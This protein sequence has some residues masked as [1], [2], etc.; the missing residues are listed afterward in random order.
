[1]VIGFERRELNLVNVNVHAGPARIGSLF[2]DNPGTIHTLLTTA[3]VGL[4]RRGTLGEFA[5]EPDPSTKPPEESSSDLF[6]SDE[7]DGIGRSGETE[8]PQSVVQGRPAQ[9]APFGP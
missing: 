2:G 4:E 9:G 6:R 5:L 7:P 1:M 8:S 3:E